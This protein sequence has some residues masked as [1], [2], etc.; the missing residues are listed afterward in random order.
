MTHSPPRQ[1]DDRSDGELVEAINA[2]DAGAFETLYRRHRDWVVRL[3]LR[4]TRDH[5]ASLDI[6]QETFAWFL[7]R[8]PGFELRAKMTTFLYPIV[9]N[10]AI[11]QSRARRTHAKATEQLA[12]ARGEASG[13]A[14]DA[15]PDSE[16]RLAAFISR[17]P[18][19]Q[20]EALILRFVDGLSMEEIAAA[21][22]TPVGTVKSRL[23]HAIRAL[24][25]D[26][27]FG[28]YFGVEG[29]GH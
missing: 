11:S 10:L 22:E 14:R 3:A 7:G 15:E 16:G 2:G 9:R 13:E 21:T 5:E 18:E 1:G 23:H 27:A 12:R 8:F 26:P 6:L 29:N 17:L 28:R 4:F 24:R 20:R 25:E 19:A